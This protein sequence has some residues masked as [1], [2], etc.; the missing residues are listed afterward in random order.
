M[1]KSEY[2][3][4]LV[5][6][7]VWCLN[8]VSLDRLGA[9]EMQGEDQVGTSGTRGARVHLRQNKG[10]R[11]LWNT[12]E[13]SCGQ[14]S[15]GGAVCSEVVGGGCFSKGEDEEVCQRMELSLFW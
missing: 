15:K 12:P 5:G 9:P 3:G 13:G 7:G 4:F 10:D 11:S 8:G 2:S 6:E 14:D 1:L